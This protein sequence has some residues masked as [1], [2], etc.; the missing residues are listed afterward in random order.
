MGRTR[1]ASVPEHAWSASIPML[2]R[3]MVL[4]PDRLFVAG[5]PDILNEEELNANLNDMSLQA[6]AKK[7]ADAWDGKH[8]GLLYA[9]S[10][11]D[12]TKRLELT[13]DSPPVFDGMAAADGALFVVQQ[14]GTVL[15]LN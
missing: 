7:Q 12:G 6:Q 3:A 14:N 11:T 9:L 8:G 13:L 5:L 2:A 15:C 1:K 4:T 10:T